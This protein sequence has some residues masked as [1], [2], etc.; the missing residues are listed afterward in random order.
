[1]LCVTQSMTCN[2]VVIR[3]VSL[4]SCNTVNLRMLQKSHTRCQ[5]KQTIYGRYE[6]M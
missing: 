4:G 1:M 3:M 5:N 2:V 6:F